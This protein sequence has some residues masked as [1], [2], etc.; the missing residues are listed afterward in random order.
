MAK[1]FIPHTQPRLMA[2]GLSRV[3]SKAWQM[4]SRKPSGGHQLRRWHARHRTRWM[5]NMFAFLTTDANI[6]VAAVHPKAMP[7]ILTHGGRNRGMNNG[8]DARRSETSAPAAGRHFQDR[9]SQ[10]SDHQNLPV[11]FSAGPAGS[12]HG[13][14][15]PLVIASVQRYHGQMA[16]TKLRRASAIAAALILAGGLVVHGFVGLDMGSTSSTS[17]ATEMPMTTDMPM[18]GKC[19]GCAGQE[20]GMS[21]AACSAFCGA[22]IAIPS[23]AVVFNT[24]SIETLGP[25]A[26]PIVTGHAD[27]PDPDPPRPTILS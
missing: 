21:P 5:A 2:K 13:W 9:K 4:K 8:A 23:V 1:A 18:S 7:V 19:D 24:I 26:G 17:M 27:P 20:K 15:R 11:H 16:S 25:S 22:V 6:E 10:R 12:R 14:P 3:F